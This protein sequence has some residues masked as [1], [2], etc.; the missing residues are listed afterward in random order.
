MNE[1]C[2]EYKKMIHGI[3]ALRRQAELAQSPTLGGTGVRLVPYPHQLYVVK[4]VLKATQIRHLLADE[5]GL[6]KTLEAL[7]IAN[8]LRIRNKGKCRVGIVVGSENRA[9]QWRDE[10]FGRLS[11]SF[12]RHRFC[13]KHPDL[14]RNNHIFIKADAAH[15]QSQRSDNRIPD[16]GYIFYY[17]PI[18]ERPDPKI[19]DLLILD[20]IHHLSDEI[21]DPIAGHADEYKSILILSATPLLG[22]DKDRH[23][24]NLL[25]SECAELAERQAD[26]ISLHYPILKDR[27]LRSRRADFRDELPQIYVERL[28]GEPLENDHERYSEAR[29]LAKA[30]LNR[31]FISEESALL[32]TRRSV[33]GGQILSKRISDYKGQFSD[34]DEDISRLQLRCARNQGDARF[35]TLVD[36]LIDFF[37]NADY[38]SRYNE[39]RKLVI[40]AQDMPT[41]YYLES[42]L[43]DCFPDIGL[44]RFDQERNKNAESDIDSDIQSHTDKANNSNTLQ[45]FWNDPSKRILIAHN[46]ARES[47]NMQNADALVFYSLPW[48]P[49]DMEQWIGRV[50]RLGMRKKTDVTLKVIVLRGFIDEQIADVYESYDMFHKLLNIEK[51]ETILIKIANQIR[52]TVLYDQNEL[53]KRKGPSNEPEQDIMHLVPYSD[54]REIW[55]RTNTPVAPVIPSVRNDNYPTESALENWIGLLVEHHICDKSF[56]SDS[57]YSR[58]E[59]PDYYKFNVLKK[60]REQDRRCYPI[61]VLDV[62]QEEPL[63]VVPYIVHRNAIQLPPRE[64]V[65]C[66]DRCNNEYFIPL[67]FFNFGSELHDGL[68]EAFARYFKAPRHLYFQSGSHFDNGDCITPGLYYIT[69]FVIERERLPHPRLLDELPVTDQKLLRQMRDVEQTRFEAGIEADD[70]FLDMLMTGGLEIVGHKS[71]GL[72]DDRI[73]NDE[74][75]M[76][77]TT[78]PPHLHLASTEN[79]LPSGQM[80]QHAAIAREATLQRWPCNIEDVLAERAQLLRHEYQMKY[81]LLSDKITEQNRK[82]TSEASSLTSRLNHEPAKRLYEQQ[83]ELAKRHYEFRVKYL[84]ESINKVKTP[85]CNCKLVLTIKVNQE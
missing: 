69:V 74:M 45:H 68:I 54:A 1:P 25:I 70:R 62:L 61:P 6:G 56:Y 3:Q 47:Y 29:K 48:K 5:V 64:I 20:E 14:I 72:R 38:T 30:L 77:L 23:L 16:D 53:K 84:Q 28:T 75:V 13:E 73:P 44:L 46:D 37:Y 7:M 40:A 79:G 17:P 65:P 80:E 82:I 63:S 60:S 67:Q 8:A 32:F 39:Q 10:I 78:L 50:I 11:P 81:D 52:D 9:K 18:I 35:D 15:M 31:K 34:F 2:A 33:I 4:E 76:L 66:R 22:H 19:L 57:R 58:Y 71:T 42:R 26:T 41:V 49:I 59:H 36:Y 83:L 27:M 24:V 51:D 85:V 55:K 12:W 43:K 21:L